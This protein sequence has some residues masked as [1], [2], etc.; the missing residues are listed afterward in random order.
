[1]RQLNMRQAGS[2]MDNSARFPELRYRGHRSGPAPGPLLHLT[3][4]RSIVRSIRALDD[5][6]RASAKG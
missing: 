4:Q 5:P 2:R 3:V 1:M 6:P